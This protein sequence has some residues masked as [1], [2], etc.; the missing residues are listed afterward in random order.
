MNSKRHSWKALIW[1]A[2]LDAR[3]TDPGAVARKNKTK[4][5]GVSFFGAMSGYG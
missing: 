4:M 1:Q 3:R 2:Q 5:D